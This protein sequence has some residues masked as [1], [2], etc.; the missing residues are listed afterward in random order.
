MRSGN[1]RFPHGGIS[2][3][4]SSVTR[5]DTPK[6]NSPVDL[7]ED[8]DSARAKDRRREGKREKRGRRSRWLWF[9]SIEIR[10]RTIREKFDQPAIRGANFPHMIAPLHPSNL[11]RGSRGFLAEY[12]R[13]QKSICHSTRLTFFRSVEKP[14]LFL[15]HVNLYHQRSPFPNQ[16]F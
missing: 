11:S 6:I 13:V 1:D 9:V 16:G 3:V 5:F 7:A 4:S 8:R 12:N 2:I 15:F 10:S 14:I